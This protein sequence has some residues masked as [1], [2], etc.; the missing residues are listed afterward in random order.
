MVLLVFSISIACLRVVVSVPFSATWSGEVGSISERIFWRT[1][2]A[3]PCSIGSGLDSITSRS[4]FISSR[5]DNLESFACASVYLVPSFIFSSFCVV[6][7]TSSAF[8]LLDRRVFFCCNMSRSDLALS[9]AVFS[10]TKSE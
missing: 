8:L 2:S 6:S 3:L 9:N 4:R 10:D 7:F 1:L 5:S